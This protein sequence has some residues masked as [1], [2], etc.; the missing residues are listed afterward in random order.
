MEYEFDYW[1]LIYVKGEYYSSTRIEPITVYED[2]NIKKSDEIK[3]S[4]DN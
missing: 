1:H 4:L 3:N 2:D